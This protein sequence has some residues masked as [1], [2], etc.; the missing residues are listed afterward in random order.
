MPLLHSACCALLLLLVAGCGKDRVRGTQTQL[1]IVNASP[2]AGSLELQQNLRPLGTGSFGYLTGAEWQNPVYVNADSGFQN[3]QVRKGAATIANFLLIN[4]GTRNSLWLYDTVT[5][6]RFRYL[7]LEDQLDTPGRTKAK[8]RFLHLSPDADTLNL[9]FN[10][11]VVNADWSYFSQEL[12][13]RTPLAQF[14]VVD[15]GRV[16]FRIRQKETQSVLKEYSLQF[17]SNGVYTFVL[18]GYRNRLGADSLSLTRI[19]HN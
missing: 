19:I 7:M 2:N 15:T 1:L 16:Q 13:N 5:A 11:A 8:I 18:K 12:V 10:S 9:L 14:F 17:T 6:D 4:R 3:Y